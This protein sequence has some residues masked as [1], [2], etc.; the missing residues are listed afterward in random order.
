M[1]ERFKRKKQDPYLNMM[2]EVLNMENKLLFVGQIQSIDV[3][4]IQVRE[5]RGRHVPPAIFNTVVKLKCISDAP[6]VEILY[7]KLSGNT[8]TWWRLD[9]LEEKRVQDNRAYYRQWINAE[10]MV[11][12]AVDLTEG[13]EKP[14]RVLDISMG[15]VLLRCDE[16]F[17]VGDYLL[18]LQTKILKE[19][20]FELTCFVRRVAEDRNGGRLYGC[21]FGSIPIEEEERLCRVLF[22]AQ[23][24]EIREKR[25]H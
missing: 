6:E 1:F 9:R 22:T 2:V 12:R 7:G 23:Q 4:T 16:E 5:I 17:R 25:R 21:E 19:A 11:R 15:G 20:P 10:A 14:C 3:E 13:A 24:Q 18:L 8:D